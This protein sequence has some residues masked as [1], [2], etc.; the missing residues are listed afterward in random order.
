MLEA[1][2]PRTPTVGARLI[3]GAPDTRPWVVFSPQIPQNDEG[4]RIEPPPSAPNAIG[5]NPAATAYPDPPEE[6]PQ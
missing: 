1:M 3:D 6:P 5:T 2:G 4:I